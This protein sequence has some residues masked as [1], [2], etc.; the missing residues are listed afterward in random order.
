MASLYGIKAAKLGSMRQIKTGA[1]VGKYMFQSEFVATMPRG[2]TSSFKRKG[3]TA[4]PI[5]DYH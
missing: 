2:Y 5:Q 4:L 3:K 1:K